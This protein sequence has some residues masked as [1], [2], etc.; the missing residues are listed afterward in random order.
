MEAA[1]T[2]PDEEYCPNC[3]SWV[4]YLHFNYTSGWCND[5]SPHEPQ[6]IHC[7][8]VLQSTHRTTCSSCR[9]ELWLARHADEI[10]FLVVCK[11]YTVAQAKIQ[12]AKMIRPICQACFKPILGGKDGAL[13]HKNKPKCHSAYVRYKKL[14]KQGNLTTLDALAMIRDGQ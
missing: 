8:G 11:G 14:V 6:C 5:C 10:E 2:S 12:I 4:V 13:F 3:G 9:Q 1:L 7:G